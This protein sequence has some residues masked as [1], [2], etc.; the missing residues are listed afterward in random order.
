MPKIKK[1][2]KISPEIRNRV[3]CKILNLK[4]FPRL[5]ENTNVLLYFGWDV[6]CLRK[7]RDQVNAC[8]FILLKMH[9]FYFIMMHSNHIE[10]HGGP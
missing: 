3:I 6:Y 5:S 7:Q 9:W 2:K 4:Y 1:K 8:S 10:N